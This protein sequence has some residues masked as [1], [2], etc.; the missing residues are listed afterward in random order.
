M[1]NGMPEI[2]ICLKTSIPFIQIMPKKLGTFKGKNIK[3]I[4]KSWK[5]KM[6]RKAKRK[7]R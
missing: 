3:K 4:E 6:K 7:F 2:W 1:M 5:K